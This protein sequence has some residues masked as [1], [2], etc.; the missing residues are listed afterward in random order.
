MN[1]DSQKCEKGRG[2]TWQHAQARG[3][4]LTLTLTLSLSLNLNVTLPPPPALSPSLA[5]TQ[6]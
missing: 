5:F 3:L 1:M 6:A 2:V 4:T